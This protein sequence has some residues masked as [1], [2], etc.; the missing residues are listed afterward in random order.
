MLSSPTA[1]KIPLYLRLAAEGKGS[2]R[3]IKVALLWP[4]TPRPSWQPQAVGN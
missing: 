2:D 1:H 4:R 3:E